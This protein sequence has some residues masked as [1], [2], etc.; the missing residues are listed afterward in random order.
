VQKEVLKRSQKGLKAQIISIA[1]VA[2]ILLIFSAF[3]FSKL[4]GWTPAEGK[5]AI[6]LSWILIIGGWVVATVRLW[7][8]W[9][10]KKYEITEDAFIVH[11]K[12]GNF[13]KSQAIYRYESILSVKMTQGFLGK[14]YN[15]GDV[16]LTIPKLDKDVIMNDIENPMEQLAM[17]QKR[18]NDK[19]KSNQSLIT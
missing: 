19:S 16:R 7:L 8:N 9:N 18:I 10:N 14:K 6:S 17:V 15:Y 2:V 3:I 4:F 11:G 13:G 5:I 12:A 1:V